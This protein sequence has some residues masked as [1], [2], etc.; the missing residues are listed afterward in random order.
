MTLNEAALRKLDREESFKLTL[1][2]QNLSVLREYYEKLEFDIIATKLVNSKLCN[3]MKLLERQSWLNEQYSRK[4]CLKMFGVPESII[5]KDLEGKALNLFEKNDIVIHPDNIEVCH[6]V[7]CN[8][9]P[10]KGYQ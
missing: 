5:D 2:Y 3:Q 8:A 1:E 4:E 6:W 10:R 9:E 7:K